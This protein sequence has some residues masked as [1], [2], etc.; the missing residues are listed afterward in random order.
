M[1]AEEEENLYSIDIKVEHTPTMYGM[2]LNA[3]EYLDLQFSALEAEEN[4]SLIL[5]KI[6]ATVDGESFPGMKVTWGDQTDITVYICRDAYMLN[7]K[8]TSFD[9]DHTAEWLKWFD[10]L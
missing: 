5:E 4:P 1:Y 3:E 9:G 8:L 10:L 2:L 6:T 7:L